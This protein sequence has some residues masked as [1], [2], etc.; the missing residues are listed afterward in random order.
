MLIYR[1]W[2]VLFETGQFRPATRVGVLQWGRMV[3][4]I[5]LSFIGLAITAAAQ[6]P[7]APV[8]EIHTD[9]AGARVSSRLYGL[10][11]EEINYSYDGGLY[12]ELV[13][14]RTLMDPQELAHW[15]LVQERGG[16]GAMSLDRSQKFTDAIPLS[17]KLTVT[18]AAGG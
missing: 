9:R 3:R 1:K 16:A 2:P 17:L 6:E 12:A 18:Q 15:S 5:C 8:L 7:V 13:R 11:T 10:M 4:P 14:N